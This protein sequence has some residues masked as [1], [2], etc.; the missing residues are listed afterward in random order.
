MKRDAISKEAQKV[1]AD[2]CIFKYDA[3]EYDRKI[4]DELNFFIEGLDYEATKSYMDA[5]LEL[6]QKRYIWIYGEPE[7]TE[8]WRKRFVFVHTRMK[9]KYYIWKFLQQIYGY[10]VKQREERTPISVAD[11]ALLKFAKSGFY[12]LITALLTAI[13]S[14]IDTALNIYNT[15]R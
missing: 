12:I 15:F 3:K 11:K 1:L 5:L 7:C 8:Y 6:K 10:E 14:I 2:Y 4:V 9:G 13:A